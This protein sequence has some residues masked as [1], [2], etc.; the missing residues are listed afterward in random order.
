MCA[1]K[2]FCNN[3]GIPQQTKKTNVRRTWRNGTFEIVNHY[4]CPCCRNTE[5]LVE[6]Y[7]NPIT[8][9]RLA[10]LRAM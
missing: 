6:V 7:G 10:T 1:K 4:L 5:T 8:V 3:R 9:A 2:C